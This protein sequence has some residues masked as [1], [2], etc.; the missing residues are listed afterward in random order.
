MSKKNPT[1]KITK[2]DVQKAIDNN[3][4][5]VEFHN[6]G[7]QARFEKNKRIVERQATLRKNAK[8]LAAKAEQ[9]RNDGVAMPEVDHK[10]VT[11]LSQYTD[12]Q[13]FKAISMLGLT[14]TDMMD[15]GVDTSRAL[16]IYTQH[17]RKEM[18]A[19]ANTNIKHSVRVPQKPQ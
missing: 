1:V 9:K 4:S 3:Y 12:E 17:S 6:K 18:E 19:R 13:L 10:H 15:G 8:V 16:S 2:G 7:A 11:D 5:N 14:V